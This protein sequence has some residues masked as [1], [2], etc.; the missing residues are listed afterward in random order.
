MENLSNDEAIT[1]TNLN[2]STE[3]T[4]SS[5]NHQRRSWVMTSK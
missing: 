1:L 5:K 3:G 2:P 4:S